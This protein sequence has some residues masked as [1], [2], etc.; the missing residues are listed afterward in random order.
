M[1]AQH[2]Y[3][4]AW[5]NLL[6]SAGFLL[7]GLNKEMREAFGLSI[8]EQDLL[9]QIEFRGD[10][11]RF[12]DL[13]Q[14]MNL[15]KAG[16]TKMMDRLEKMKLVKRMPSAKDRRALNA[17]LTKKGEGLVPRTRHLLRG[18]VKEHF[19]AHLS[20]RE[21]RQLTDALQK[22]LAGNERKEF[23][24]QQVRKPPE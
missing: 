20:D 15:S 24:N 17:R 21:I 11:L 5:V 9:S 6:Y 4:F 10:K 18:W 2:E 14:R 8:A 3:M 1:A 23:L 13:S 22:V 7:T 19:A 16:I 12:V